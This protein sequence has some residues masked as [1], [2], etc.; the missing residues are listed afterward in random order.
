LRQRLRLNQVY[1]AAADIDTRRFMN[2]LGQYVDIVDR[3]SVAGNLNDSALRFS[4]FVNRSSRIGRPDPTE[5]DTEQ[6]N[7]LIEASRKL[8]FDLIKVDPN[9]IPKL[10]ARSHAFWYEDPWVS[11][12]L[13]GLFLLNADP[14][15]RGL[16]A[17]TTERGTRYWTFPPDFGDRVVRLFTPAPATVPAA[18]RP[19]SGPR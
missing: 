3:V 18:T 2:E 11:G 5:L 4:A 1:F 8:G 10:P 16:D 14:P 6:T 9:A 12:D 17:Q 15:R 7:F 19:P 13:L